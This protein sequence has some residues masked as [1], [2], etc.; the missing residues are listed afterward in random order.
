MKGNSWLY[1]HLVVGSV[2]YGASF[3]AI[4]FAASVA[5]SHRPLTDGLAELLAW[6]VISAITYLQL[7]GRRNRWARLGLY[8][9]VG[10]A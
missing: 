8:D 7:R 9:R 1:R 2:L 10:N 3:G 6:P 4:W 5:F